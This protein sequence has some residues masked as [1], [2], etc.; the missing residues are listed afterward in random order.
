[1]DNLIVFLV[2]GFAFGSIYALAA[3][4]LVLTYS[5]SGIFNFGHGA[6]AMLGAFLYWQMTE[7]WGWPPWLGFLLVLGVAGPF[8]GGVVERGIMRGLQGTSET[9]RLMVS[10]SLLLGALGLGQVIWSTQGRR[11]PLLLGG[12]SPITLAGYDVSWHQIITVGAAMV[13]ALALW[14]VLTRT[15]LGISMRSVVDDRN[16]ARLAGA[17]P[18]R[19]AIAA[20]AIGASMAALAGILTTGGRTL[21]HFDLILLVVN[22]YAAAMFGRLASLPHTYLGAVVLGLVD[23]FVQVYL[24]SEWFPDASWPG[25][26]RGV[27][28][29]LVL[30]GVL[31]VLRP[32]QLKTL[33]ITKIREVVPDPSYRTLAIGC[34][35]FLAVSYVLATAVFDRS[36]LSSYTG[37]VGYAIIMLS[38]VPLVG[39]GGQISLCQ[40]AFAGL[41]GVTMAH[42]AAGGSILGLAVPT[43]GL[44]PTVVGLILAAVIPGLV[45]AAVALPALRLSGLYLA[46][47]T[48]AFAV[49]VER[50]VMRELPVM[51]GG[52][53]AV[54]RLELPGLSLE[55]DLTNL[56]F[57]V[58]VFSALA[59]MVV[60]IRKGPFGRRLQAMKDS[61]AACATMGLDL[62][63]TKLSV[64]A[65][66]AAM[67][68][69]G[70]AL[71]FGTIGSLPIDRLSIVENLNLLLMAVV[72]GVTS[73][74]GV[75]FGG[76]VLGS[77]D[78]IRAH[79]PWASDA[80]LVLPGLIGISLGRNPNGA[81][82]EMGRN[83]RE[84]TRRR[85][86]AELADSLVPELVDGPLDEAQLAE[87]DAVLDLEGVKRRVLARG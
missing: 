34:G 50:F 44:D 57:Q 51:S 19:A 53:T 3:S 87:L 61:P 22:A 18:D 4:G 81:V 77:F 47:A 58:V 56:V 11:L 86:D 33:G 67:A 65:L 10:V 72:G 5:T 14:A 26:L 49:F 55:S 52:S 6:F 54:P 79:A 41:G 40:F 1:M 64:F 29:V 71:Y 59:T 66:S 73:V 17:R 35:L 7:G 15:R 21:S 13:T 43:F 39:L 45:G 12:E 8:F 48:M 31:L 63:R 36:D 85:S 25:S 82:N 84:L 42:V 28:S 32:P 78:I 74:A 83:F 69:L 27:A 9:T 30:F 80:L 62:T 20:W 38:L 70:G 46:L 76:L 75:L 24:I 2:T 68:G 37:G 16:L 23:S 60:A